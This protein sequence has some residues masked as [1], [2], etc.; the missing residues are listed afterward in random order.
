MIKPVAYLKKTGCLG[1]TLL[2]LTLVMFF[3]AIIAGLS[4][5]FVMSTLDRMELQTS[6]RKVASALRYARSEAI[7][8]KK[9][10]VFSGNLDRNQFW[11]T[12]G[13]NNET[14]KVT[15]LTNPIRLDHFINEGEDNLFRD[16]EFTVTFFPQ[17][18]SSGG[19]IGM[20]INEYR[21]SEN[22]YVVSIDPITGKT[23]IKQTK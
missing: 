21:N 20:N 23:K 2:E 17:G 7:A 4:T 18:N 19:L 16:N 22:Y 3:M 13:Y 12:Q 9:P 10:V 6:A 5:P 11:V 15:S 14:P 1:F 8:S